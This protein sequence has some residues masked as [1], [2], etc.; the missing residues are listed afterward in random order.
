M[1]HYIISTASAPM[2][3]C[4]YEQGKGNNPKV[5]RKIRINGYAN[6]KDPN[7]SRNVIMPRCAITEITDEEWELLQKNSSFKYHQEK[8]FVRHSDVHTEKIVDQGMTKRDKSAQIN[9]WEFANGQDERFSP[10]EGAG[11]SWARAGL[12]NN[13]TGAKGFQFVD[14]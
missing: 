8:G 4:I 9:D 3:Y 11:M 1:A 6:V 5:V 10:M 7:S 13:M 2:Q 14:E 12:G